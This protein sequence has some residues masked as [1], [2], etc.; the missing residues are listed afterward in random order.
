MTTNVMNLFAVSLLAIAA[1][2][3]GT[4]R[5][6][7]RHLRRYQQPAPRRERALR[8]CYDTAQTDARP[9]RE[10]SPC[11]SRRKQTGAKNHAN[12]AV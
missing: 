11:N 7:N 10:P 4:A 5:D 12:S 1:A 9:G 3:R 2:C 8:S 6:R